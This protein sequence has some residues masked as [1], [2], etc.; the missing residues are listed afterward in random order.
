VNSSSILLR[1]SVRA[2]MFVLTL[3]LPLL[4]NELV[5]ARALILGVL[6]S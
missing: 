1:R 6:L 4:L 2:Q 5:E 3:S